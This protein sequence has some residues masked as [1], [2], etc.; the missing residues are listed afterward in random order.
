MEIEDIR[1]KNALAIGNVDDEFTGGW[2][3]VIGVGPFNGRL[4]CSSC[5][6]PL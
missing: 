1:R 2:I 4:L 3:K 5:R 6:V